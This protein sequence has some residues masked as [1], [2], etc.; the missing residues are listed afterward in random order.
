MTA[1]DRLT[2]R[3]QVGFL[4]AAAVAVTFLRSSIYLFGGRMPMRWTSSSSASQF[5]ELLTATLTSSPSLLIA[6][7]AAAAAAASHV[8]S[9]TA[10]AVVI[11]ARE[12]CGASRRRFTSR[13]ANKRPENVSQ[14]L[15]SVPPADDNCGSSSSS[16]RGLSAST[17]CWDV[18]QY[19][20]RAS[21]HRRR[22]PNDRSKHFST[23]TKDSDCSYTDASHIPIAGGY[24]SDTSGNNRRLNHVT[25]RATDWTSGDGSCLTTG[26]TLASA[27]PLLESKL[28]PPPRPFLTAVNSGRTT[29]IIGCLMLGVVWSLLFHHASLVR[30]IDNQ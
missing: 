19:E 8:P 9:A 17:A 20:L 14:L 24:R 28:A 16:S 7:A 12:E 26:R 11:V 2:A 29:S 1:T 25:S 18:R 6:T 30:S 13:S 10:A 3:R 5:D 23:K 4:R 21:T 15:S 27:S 22:V